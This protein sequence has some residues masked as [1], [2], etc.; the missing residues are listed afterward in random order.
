MRI[1]TKCTKK[2]RPNEFNRRAKSK[3][4]LAYYC[5]VCQALGHKNAYTKNK[6]QYADKNWERRKKAHKYVREYKQRAKCAD[7]GESRWQCLSFDHLKDKTCNISGI[8]KRFLSLKRI[9]QEINKCEVVCH[10]CHSIRT[11]NRTNQ[12]GI[13]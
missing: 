10:N 7:C 3:D 6:K 11:Y 2:L 4:G 1:C 5:K 9:Q 13:V 12:W 8:E